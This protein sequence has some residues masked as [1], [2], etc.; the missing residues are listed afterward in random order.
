MIRVVRARTLPGISVNTTVTGT[1][2]RG[3]GTEH[4]FAYSVKA[5]KGTSK[6]MYSS[7]L[8]NGVDRGGCRFGGC[9]I[10]REDGQTWIEAKTYARKDTS[11]N[12][13]TL[14]PLDNRGVADAFQERVRACGWTWSRFRKNL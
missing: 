7:S 5:P 11:R 4:L 12:T 13:H 10:D 2:K 3:Q 14:I 8:G 1:A 9:T 6:L